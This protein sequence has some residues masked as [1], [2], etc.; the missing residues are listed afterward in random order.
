[1]GY[2]LAPGL[3]FCSVD[4]RCIFLDSARDRYFCLSA[5]AEGSLLGLI[6]GSDLSDRDVAHLAGLVD[7]GILRADASDAIP[8]SC[9]PPT[10]ARHSLYDAADRAGLTCAVQAAAQFAW[11]RGRL[12]HGGLAASLHA[13]RRRKRHVRGPGA[14][15]AAADV[16]AAFRRAATLATTHDFCLAHSLAVARALFARGIPASLVVG[17]HMRPFSA[18]CWVQFG[19]ALVNDSIDNVCHY[20]PILVI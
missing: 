16:A 13:L 1:M 20:T 19:D 6:A 17:V 18:H 12:R 14:Q 4:E 3:S 7:R 8:L 15:Q 9:R 10:P 11:A 2:I 5:A